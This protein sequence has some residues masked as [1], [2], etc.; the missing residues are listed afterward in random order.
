MVT[1]IIERL[2]LFLICIGGIVYTILPV[3]K[4]K[5]ISIIAIV[6]GVL[7]IKLGGKHGV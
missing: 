2:A 3:L 4:F 5:F 6:T 1:K 7:I